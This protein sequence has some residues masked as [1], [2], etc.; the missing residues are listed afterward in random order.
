MK[1]KLKAKTISL[2]TLFAVLICA[3][4]AAFAVKIQVGETAYAAPTEELKTEVS[5]QS[6]EVSAQNAATLAAAWN[7]AVQESLDGNGKQVTFTSPKTGRLNPTKH[8]QPLSAR[9]W[10][11]TGAEFTYPQARIS[12]LI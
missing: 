11:S 12:Y 2:I 10:V 6:E 7:S 1:T 9:V 3:V 5:A 8:I 4:F